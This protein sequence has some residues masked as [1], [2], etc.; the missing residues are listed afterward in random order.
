MLK[1]KLDKVA[2][3][4]EEDMQSFITQVVGKSNLADTIKVEDGDGL[5]MYVN[6]YI[7]Y[8]EKG[9]R[10]KTKRIPIAVLAQ[11]AKKKGISLNNSE[12]YAV[13]Q[14][15]FVKGIVGKSNLTLKLEEQYNLSFSRYYK[16][17]VEPDIESQID[18]FITNN[19]KNGNSNK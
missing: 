11:W 18:N 5:K 4:V 15:I 8:I 6:D 17:I 9:R 19:Y 12:L 3:L 2:S 7:K 10:A 14:S 13:Q 1:L 16:A